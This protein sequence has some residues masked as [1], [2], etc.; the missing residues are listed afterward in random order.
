MLKHRLMAHRGIVVRRSRERTQEDRDYLWEPSVALASWC[1]IPFAVM[2]A[3]PFGLD[4]L[5]RDLAMIAQIGAAAKLTHADELPCRREHVPVVLRKALILL[6]VAALPST[7]FGPWVV[8]GMRDA[9]VSDRKDC[10]DG[11]AIVTGLARAGHSR[12]SSPSRS[13]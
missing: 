9:P 4:H 6:S 13:P 1:F 12:V 2:T 3:P 8:A 5:T 11:R 10:G 7:E